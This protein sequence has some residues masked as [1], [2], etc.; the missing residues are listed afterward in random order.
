MER[1]RRAGLCEIAFGSR[2]VHSPIT[3]TRHLGM[4]LSSSTIARAAALSSAFLVAWNS[5]ADEKP[6]G[7]LTALSEST[8]N[9][10]VDTS[11]TFVSPPDSV[12]AAAVAVER[13]RRAGRLAVISGAAD[14]NERFGAMAPFAPAVPEPSM[15]SLLIGGSIGLLLLARRGGNRP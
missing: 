1:P 15:S 12:L 14:A 11:V 3:A 9:G 2:S 7:I 6:A 13:R 8:I 5:R 10:Y 4:K